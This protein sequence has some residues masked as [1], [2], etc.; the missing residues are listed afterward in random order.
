MR[1]LSENRNL[2][3]VLV[4]IVALLGLL[5]WGVRAGR[6]QEIAAARAEARQK[7]AAWHAHLQKK[8]AA[9]EAHLQREAWDKAHPAEVAQRKAEARAALA[10][11]QTERQA[12]A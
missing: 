8:A 10:R 5:V 7:A 3:I 6:Q 1:T 12:A 11:Q 4:V 9:W 2:L